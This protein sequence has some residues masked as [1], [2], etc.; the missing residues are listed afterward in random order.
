M[1]FVIVG[2]GITCSIPRVLIYPTKS[3]SKSSCG[4]RHKVAPAEK[5]VKTS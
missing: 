3:D 1:S 4:A 5:I 2:V